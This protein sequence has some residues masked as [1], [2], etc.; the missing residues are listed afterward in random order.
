MRILSFY[1]GKIEPLAAGEYELAGAGFPLAAPIVFGLCNAVTA[2]VLVLLRIATGSPLTAAAL[3]LVIYYLLKGVRLIDGYVDCAEGVT[4]AASRNVDHETIWNAIRSPGNGAFGILWVGLLVIVQFSLFHALSAQTVKESIAIFSLCA[5]LSSHAL[6][7]AHWGKQSYM[8]DSR[9]VSFGRRLDKK[10]FF[11]SLVISLAFSFLLILMIYPLVESVIIACAAVVFS[12]L[13]GFLLKLLLH[14]TIVHYNG[15]IIG[16]VL[17][18]AENMALIA[19]V[20]ALR[21]AV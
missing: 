16:A 3:A 8:Q 5:V 21:A 1:A 10:S 18:V 12:S 14:K 2:A 11:L 20:A 7:S 17:L 9:F 19:I 15:D 13:M 6:V 4:M